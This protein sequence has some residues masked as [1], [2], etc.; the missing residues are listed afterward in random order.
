MTA[1]SLRSEPRDRGVASL[2]AVL[3]SLVMLMIIAV[4]VLRQYAFAAASS[5]Q[6]RAHA[7]AVAVLS[8]KAIEARTG[9]GTL[10]CHPPPTPPATLPVEKIDQLGPDKLTPPDGFRITCL[11]A[12][13]CWPPP[14]TTLPPPA[15][16][17]DPEPP[18]D[19]SQQ[20]VP[21]RT[22]SVS[23]GPEDGGRTLEQTVVDPP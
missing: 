14:V 22:V 3:V 21:S 8:W 19:P 12:S 10:F 7:E 13:V 5:L 9:T 6:A 1:T 2:A 11:E 20:E 4:G 18:C 15:L 17:Y 23:W 16:P